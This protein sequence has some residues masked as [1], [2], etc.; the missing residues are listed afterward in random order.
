MKEPGMPGVLAEIRMDHPP[1]PSQKRYEENKEG[2]Q[3]G[4]KVAQMRLSCHACHVSKFVITLY[5]I[6]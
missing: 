1:N 5:N 4:H 2:I 3:C 6:K